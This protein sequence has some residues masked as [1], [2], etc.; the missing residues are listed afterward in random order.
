MRDSSARSATSISVSLRKS[1]TTAPSRMALRTEAS[2]SSG[3]TR[4]AGG[5]L[6]PMR[7]SA[8]STSAS[9][10]RRPASDA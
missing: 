1:G 8:P 5:G 4:I 2:A 10:P 6:S 9:T 3:F 7:C